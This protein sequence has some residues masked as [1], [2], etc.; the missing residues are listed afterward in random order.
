MAPTDTEKPWRR[1]EGPW[2]LKD[3]KPREGSDHGETVRATPI[4]SPGE[5]GPHDRLGE[6]VL[7][8]TDRGS[9]ELGEKPAIGRVVRSGGASM[10]ALASPFASHIARLLAHKHALG[11]AYHREKKETRDN[12][13]VAL[14][15]T[16][17]DLEEP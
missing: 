3:E 2:L 14:A 7:G 13:A 4:R 11:I 6:Y 12:P 1:Y 8:P 16:V 5:V 9:L 15:S 10:T 17:A